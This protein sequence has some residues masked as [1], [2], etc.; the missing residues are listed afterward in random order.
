MVSN[1]SLPPEIADRSAWYGPDLTACA[2]WIELLCQTEISEVESATTE[3]ISSSHDLT[4]LNSDGFALPTLGPHLQQLLAEVLNG[5]GFVL[6]RGLPIQ[7]WTQSEAAI[8]F[9]G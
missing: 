1:F 3:L 5:R 6:I 7:R 8:A 4:S 9:L 2:D